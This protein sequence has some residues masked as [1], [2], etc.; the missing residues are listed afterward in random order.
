MRSMSLSRKPEF[1]PGSYGRLGR[2]WKRED[3]RMRALQQLL[4]RLGLQHG[5]RDGSHRNDGP[6]ILAIFRVRNDDRRAARREGNEVGVHN[7]E[8]PPGGGLD[9]KRLIPLEQLTEQ[10]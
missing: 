4:V 1:T 2:D 10:G 7:V 6:L 9:P 5:G 8:S 3:C